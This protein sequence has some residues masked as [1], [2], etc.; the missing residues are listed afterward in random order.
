MQLTVFASALRFRRS[1]AD[2]NCSAFDCH[3]HHLHLSV[4][5]PKHIVLFRRSSRT[6]S[7]DKHTFSATLEIGT[8]N[9]TVG[10][11]TQET[12]AIAVSLTKLAHSNFDGLCKL[13]V[14]GGRIYLCSCVLAHI[15]F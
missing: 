11:F 2:V 7:E 10:A 15:R 5:L 6:S 4:P 9:L 13:V 1:V 12:N 8:D 3:E 14:R